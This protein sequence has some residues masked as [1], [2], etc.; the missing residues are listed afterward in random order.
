MIKSYQKFIFLIVLFLFNYNTYAQFY[1]AGQDPACIKWQQIKTPHFKLIFPDSFSE[2]ANQIANYLEFAYDFDTVTL[3][4]KP[5]K[6]AVIIHNR[7]VVSNG[8]VTWAP[9]RSE[10]YSCPPQDMYAQPWVEQLSIHEYR[11]AVQVSQMY[12]GMSNVL[13]IPFGELAIGSIAGVY[14]PRWFLEGDAVVMETALTKSGRGRLPSF[15]MDLKAQLIEKGSFNYNKAIFGSYKDNIPD[16]YTLGYHLVAYS[17]CKYGADIW[18]KTLKYIARNPYMVV[19]FAQGLKKATGKT[20]V[21]IYKESLSFFDSLW[22]KQLSKS[23]YNRFKSHTVR[24]NK[25]FTNYRFPNY[26]NDSEFIALKYGIDDIPRFVKLDKNGKESIVFTQGNDFMHSLSYSENL[27]VWAEQYPGLRWDHES[28][29]VIKTYD[30]VKRKI[31]TITH[32]TRYFAP[33]ISHDATKIAAIEVDLQ[34]NYF[35]VILD[36]QTGKVLNKIASPENA[37]LATPSW[38]DDD[39]TVVMIATSSNGR[40]FAEYHQDNAKIHFKNAFVHCEM[41]G[42]AYFKNFIIYNDIYGGVDNVFAMDTVSNT[43]YQLTYSKYG[44]T[45][46]CVSFDGSQ[47]VY[48]DFTVNGYDIVS[49]AIQPELWNPLLIPKDSFNLPEQLASQEKGVINFQQKTKQYEITKYSKISHLINIHSWAPLSINA[50]NQTAAPGI[51]FMSH[52]LLSTS[53]LTAGY[54]YIREENT[55]KYYLDYTYKGLFP[56]IDAS[57][58]YRIK[59]GISIWHD[60]SRHDF[61]YRECNV[62]L[63]LSIPLQFPTSKYYTKLIPSVNTTL[64]N[65]SHDASTPSKFTKGN[66][67]S[68]DYRIYAY[69]VL[70][71]SDRDLYPKWGQTLELNFRHTPFGIYNYGNIA[72]AESYL[73]L[74]SIINHHGFKF[75]GGIQKRTEGSSNYVF[76][77][78]INYPLGSYAIYNHWLYSAAVSYFYPLLYP[79][80]S[81]GSLMYLKRLDMNLFYGRAIAAYENRNT[82]QQ[83]LEGEIN[84]EMHILRFLAPINIGYRFTYLPDNNSVIHEVLLGIN[85]SGF[86]GKQFH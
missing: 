38:S 85:F 10:W 60:N 37:F 74:P 6:L 26:I 75:Y 62:K 82:L 16:P 1:D 63:G 59:N 48:S 9:K 49:I 57:I 19:P 71:T 70:K 7:T 79:D 78:I 40:A 50:N 36:A 54:E 53:F 22:T 31:K 30:I 12:R 45:D 33:C 58:D 67:N 68:I 4:H 56:V 20:T 15:N 41:S 39:R 47:L 18:D 64:I 17:R 44:A 51:S 80:F 14:L 3:R 42:A 61:T 73:Y 27:I 77:D 23:E 52:N 29:A 28:Y 69:H 72:S 83:S 86:G 25:N 81:I 5:K 76:S 11:H 13:N 21:G 55:G 8:F 65:I 35:L 24:E 43:I 66:I 84:S 34:N 2:K 32:K 46:P